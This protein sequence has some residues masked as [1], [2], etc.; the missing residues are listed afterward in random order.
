MTTAAEERTCV[1]CGSQFLATVTV[2]GEGRTVGPRICVGCAEDEEAADLGPDRSI[3]SAL[4]DLGV[5]VRKHGHMSL[6]DMGDTPAVLAARRFVADTLEAGRYRAVKGLWLMGSDTGVGKSQVAVSVMRELLTEGYRGRIVFDRARALITTLQDR[7]GKGD[8]DATTDVRRKAGV[9]I[10]DDAGTEKP[11]PDAFRIIED[12][13]DAREGHPNVWTGNLT[14]EELAAH[15]AD[16]DV[17]G[18]F[19]S[20][21]GPRNFRYVEMRGEDRR[22]AA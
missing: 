22:F 10:L 16:K 3:E 20:R 12:I 4:A 18:R 17:A 11:T 15:W 19:T 8:V 14:H 9:W 5:N 2:L 13:L 1:E 7:Y 6:D 21:I